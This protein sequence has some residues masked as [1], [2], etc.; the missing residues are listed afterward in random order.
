M[1]H[2]GALERKVILPAHKAVLAAHS[3][4]FKNL[5]LYSSENA[6]A[7]NPSSRLLKISGFSLDAVQEMLNFMYSE[8]RVPFFLMPKYDLSELGE[9]LLLA[10]QYKCSDWEATLTCLAIHQHMNDT[11]VCRL[12][13]L[14]VRNRSKPL[15]TECLNYITSS[16]KGKAGSFG[17]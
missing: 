17:R 16:V 6:S 14:A 3:T 8:K 15:Q 9:L 2:P 12:L 1:I 13:S 4:R 11:N 10:S 7:T 5:F